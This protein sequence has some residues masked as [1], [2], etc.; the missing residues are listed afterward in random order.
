MLRALVSFLLFLV[1]ESYGNAQELGEAEALIQKGAFPRAQFLLEHAL[2]LDPTNTDIL[3]RLGYVH[4]RQRNL[5]AAEQQFR[6]VVK[7]APPALHSRYFLGRIA[8]AENRP[9]ESIEW[10]EPVV[11]SSEAIFDAPSQLAKAYELTGQDARAAEALR[12]AVAQRPWDSALY[13]RL[14]RLYQKLDRPELARD[15]LATSQRMKSADRE[16]VQ[17]LQELAEYTARQQKPEALRVCDAL[18]ARSDLD[19]NTWVAAG[20][21]LGRAGWQQEAL[22]AFEAA[23]RRERSLFQAQ[24]NQGL[25]L[26]KLGR[27]QEAEQPLR[28]AVALLPQSMEA[29]SA[30]GLVYVLANRFRDAKP[31]LESAHRLEPANRKVTALLALACIRTGIP[32]EAIPLLRP[33]LAAPN[34]EPQP[35]LLLMEALNAAE[36][37]AGALSVAERAR[38]RFPDA[39]QVQMAAAQQLARIGRYQEAGK[40]FARVVE[41]APDNADAWLGKADALQKAGEHA[42]AVESYERALA[43][44]ADLLAARLGL[45]RSLV[46]LR[47]FEDARHSLEQALL[48]HPNAPQLRVE[49]ARVYAR[50]GKP[51]LA[52]EQ[53]HILEQLQH[54]SP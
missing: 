12:A 25:A 37:P 46:A 13:Y 9:K 24:F 20:V 10:L 50:L 48:V 17:L 44:S 27:A 6:A 38:A 3:Y 7:L 39:P 11:A 2:T 19:P 4:Y 32:R 22:R 15:A 45:A 28:N 16:S 47:R 53:T 43:L 29:N 26:L 42:R 34:P 40:G 31:P 5:K 21:L 49:L 33:L 35:F 23:A 30:L 14:G 51:E 18:L 1:Y 54:R 41:L 52:A 8:L 36:D